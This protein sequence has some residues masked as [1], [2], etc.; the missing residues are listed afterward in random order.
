MSKKLSAFCLGVVFLC[1][2]RLDAQQASG[3]ITGVVTD[4]T[5]AAVP[6][7][8]VSVTNVLT[9]ETRQAESN[10]SGTYVL[11]ALP[12]GTYQMEARKDGFK[13][14][15]RGD[16][17][18]DVNSAPTIDLHLEVG[19]L[20][21]RITVNAAPALIDTENPAIGNSRYEAQ[22]KGLPIIVREVQALVGQTAGVPYGTTDTV[23][24]NYQ[25][26]GRSAMQILSDGAQLDPF[27][28]TGW[29]AI[30]GIGRRADLTIPGVDSLAEVKW[31]TN[32]GSAE[33]IS[34]TQVIIASKT[35]ANQLHGSAFEY[36]RSGG[37][38]A[39]RWELPTR[40]SFVRH[41]FGGTVGGKIIKDKM[42]FFGGVE[43]FSHTL[44]ATLTVRQP[45]ASERSG[46]LS[47]LLQRTDTRG[48]PSPVTVFDPL[49]GQPF[50]GNIIPTNRLSPVATQLLTMIPAAPAPVGNLG[51]FN[52]FIFKPEYDK[53]QK[54]DARWDYNVSD[55]DR[56]FARTTIGHLD[57]FSR[58]SGSVPGTYGYST[59]NEWTQAVS[60]NWT[61]IIN[62]SLVATLQFTFR[63]MPFENLPSA[64]DTTFPVPITNVNAKPPFGGPPAVLINSN[65][66]GVSDLFDR[67]LF[68]YD[69]DHA[70]SVDPSVTKTIHNHTLKGGFT[71]LWGVK[72]DML[73]S[74]P[75]GRYQTVSDYNNP[76]STTSATGDAFADFLLGFPSTTDVTVGP[77]GGHLSKS[78]IGAYL[79]DDWKITSKLTINVGLR[80]DFFGFFR[81]TNLQSATSDF[82]LGKV[83]IQ[84]NSQSLIQ[85]A[86]SQFSN[87]FITASQAGLPSTFIHPNNLD[88]T[89]RFGVAYRLGPS[90]VIRG[91][92]GIYSSDITYNEFTNEYNGP[93][94]VHRSQLSRSL[95]ISQGVDVNSVYN[96][97][98]PTA[99]GSVA[100]ATAA[101][102]NIGGLMNSYPTEKSYTW[103][104]TIERDF[105]HGMALRTTYSANST[106][107]M[108][109]QVEVNACAPGP[110]ECL[111][112]APGDP[113]GR[114][115]PFFNA[116][117]AIH[118]SDGFSNFNDGEIEFSK[119]FS[120]GLLLDMNYAHSRLLGQQ[121]VATNPVADPHWSYDYG[122]V[123]AEPNDIIHWNYVL[124]LPFGKGRRLGGHMNSVLDGMFGGWSLSGL[125]TW[126]S[127]VPLTITANSGQSPT[128]ATVNRANRTGSGTISNPTP[129]VWFDTSAYQLPAFN[130]SSASRPTRQFGTAG[131][132]TVYGPHF[133]TYDMTL[134]KTFAIRE[135]YKLQFRAEAYNPLNHPDLGNPDTE[136]TSGTFG[137]VRASNASYN[138]R[139]IQ[140]GARLDF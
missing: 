95:L 7:V 57:Q 28:T 40:E 94:F 25:Q 86:F 2:V 133:F 72:A 101:M 75:Y 87:L 96:F 81:E 138:P 16:I 18:I 34:P 100:D 122:P 92:F 41:Q 106:R 98:N 49:S 59:K 85:P 137:V 66:L 4:P 48:N 65:G 136:V 20:N 76:K 121:Y 43:V 60:T 27:Q 73:A 114:K 33:Y 55:R 91:G 37:L 109:R 69:I 44:G 13:T 8:T 39:R 38:G 112:R 127:G 88:F 103:N 128:G 21:E 12:V 83:V 46:D 77:S 113:T 45:T 116:N 56:L 104:V 126:Q 1:A 62:P 6:G 139:S 134:H 70:F 115:Y 111:S 120:N 54:Y 63:N 125:G 131:V 52:A 22:L 50:A 68:N 17:R 124:D 110:T 58:F 24:G 36:Y 5:T 78:N 105:G 53:S 130:A 35:G 31:V 80:Y 9:G 132:G 42:F 26:G 79:Q 97:Q 74:P 135:H 3:K 67:L 117:F 61:R 15:S 108:S 129:A 32:G 119:R 51:S 89:P 84:D 14:M 71:Y 107:N 23:G 99:N 19:A 140:F 29:P 102:A 90:M 64:G 47:D 30:D 10:E 118:A 82:S 93:P 11:T 123:A